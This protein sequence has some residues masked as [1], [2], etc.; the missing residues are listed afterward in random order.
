[1]RRT[2]EMQWRGYLLA[3][4][5]TIGMVLLLALSV[6]RFSIVSHAESAAKVTA[7]SA[8]IRKEPNPSS[9]TIG[10]TERDKVISIKSQ[11]Q[12]TDGYTWYE[13]YVNADTLGYI[14]SDLVQITD[15]TTP[16]S[17][18]APSAST[19]TPATA[20]PA[21]STP[22]P[23]EPLVDVAA[24]NPAS[25]SVT[26]GESVRIRQNASTTSRIVDIVKSGM[27]LTI[28]GTANGSDG[29]VWYQVTFLTNGAEVTGFI[30]SDYTTVKPEELTA[31]TEEPPVQPEVPAD[32]P[33]TAP[34]VPD[35][36]P[37][38]GYGILF[39]DGQWM[40][41]DYAGKYADNP[42]DGFVVETLIE[43][44]EKNANMYKESEQTVKTQKIIIIILVILLVGAA[45]AITL[46]IF[47]VKD[48][49]DAQYFNEVENET[50]RRRGTGSQGGG[51]KGMQSAG[52]E[53]QGGRP[54]AG[55]R[56]GAQAGAQGQRPQGSRSAGAQGQQRPASQGARPAGA[57]SQQ[58]PASQGARPAGAQ[59]QQRPASQGARPAGAPQGQQRPVSQG[60]RPAGV[61]QGQQRPAPQGAPQG[62]QRPAA[63][64]QRPQGNRPAQNQQSPGWQSKNFMADEDEFEFEF[65][66]YDGDDEK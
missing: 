45:A 64:G 62:Q 47:K 35:A 28:T 32:D 19:P 6:E 29:K 14:R 3:G 59:G 33:V 27:A 37:T 34:E 16:P 1:M 17:G 13:V 38:D 58:H 36:V 23:D 49:S 51:Q 41:I 48:M 60:A 4:M 39:Q 22:V 5:V 24:V 31:Y 26:G 61:P 8:N 11:V 9:E 44:L 15:G 42:G 55:A 10:S 57:Q 21:S 53:R 56:P 46:L 18:T 20:P 52:K 12:G 40:L 63:Q 50:L 30:R 54:A 7:A 2:K 43:G 25:A 65:L 66:N